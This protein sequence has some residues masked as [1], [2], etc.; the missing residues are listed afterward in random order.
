[1][2]TILP[3]A[4]HRRGFSLIEV[5]L[6]VTIIG[7][8]ASI[9]LPI[10]SQSSQYAKARNVRNAQEM[11]SICQQAQAAGVDF[12]VPGNLDLTIANVLRGGSPSDGPFRGYVF[13]LRSL[14][15]E[16]ASKAKPYLRVVGKAL[17]VNPNGDVSPSPSG[18]T[19]ATNINSRKKSLIARL[20]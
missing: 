13:S 5:M 3:L 7:I 15:N 6:A 8:M 9:A 18:P 20:A 10:L 16:N 17:I 14:N 4:S 19:T 12:V 11:V 2:K 1:M